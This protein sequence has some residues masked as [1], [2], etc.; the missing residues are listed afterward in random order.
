MGWVCRWKQCT[1]FLTSSARGSGTSIPFH[2]WYGSYRNPR[3]LLCPNVTTEKSR[4]ISDL[5]LSS[6]RVRWPCFAAPQICNRSSRSC[7]AIVAVEEISSE[8]LDI[9]RHLQVANPNT[10]PLL[11]IESHAP[12]I[13]ILQKP[14]SLWTC[15]RDERFLLTAI[16]TLFI[17]YTPSFRILYVSI[18]ALAN[19]TVRR[20]R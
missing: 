5:T 2:T 4:P 18:V 8:V 19:S 17:N 13:Y 12:Q 15:L 10:V 14:S 1:N 9:F 6:P 11:Q 20:L 7:R 16:G 3:R